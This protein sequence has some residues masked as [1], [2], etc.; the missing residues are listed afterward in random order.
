MPPFSARQGR[1]QAHG[2]ADCFEKFAP[3]LNKGKVD[4]LITAHTHRYQYLEPKPGEHDYPMVN[5]GGPNKGRATLIRVDADK[6][7]IELT[8]TRDDGEVLEKREILPR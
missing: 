5:G 8:M 3:L 4:L 7:R 2:T 6:T 1:N